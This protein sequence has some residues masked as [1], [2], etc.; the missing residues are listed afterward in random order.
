MFFKEFVWK[1][2]LLC[3]KEWYVN[4]KYFGINLG[5]YD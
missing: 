4:D 2:V 5:Y 1:D 3:C